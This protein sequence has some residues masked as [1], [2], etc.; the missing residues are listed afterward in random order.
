MD[1]PFSRMTD[2]SHAP[3]ENEIKAWL[4]EEPYGHWKTLKDSIEARYPGMLDRQW[5]FGG[6]K[7]GWSLR[8]KASRPLCT[9]VPA[10]GRCFLLIVFGA[11]ERDKVEAVRGELSEATLAQYD[12]ATT[13]HDGKWLILTIAG[14][15]DMHDAMILLA[16]KR[17]PK[18]GP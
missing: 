17:K 16:A 14:A 8:F 7:H 13:Y 3:A 15:A 9:L 18:A 10:K 12:A 1:Q 2:G 5:L 6:R 4:G 11:K